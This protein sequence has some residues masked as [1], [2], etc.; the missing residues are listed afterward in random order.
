M[1]LI[2][3]V[4]IIGLLVSIIACS[5]ANMSFENIISND[6]DVVEIN[7]RNFNGY[8]YTMTNKEK[9]KE[10]LTIFQETSFIKT[11]KVDV[12][13]GVSLHLVDAEGNEITSI[14]PVDTN[15]FRMGETYYQSTSDIDGKV[16]AYIAEHFKH[17]NLVIEEGMVVNL[18]VEEIEKVTIKDFKKNVSKVIDNKDSIISIVNVF[19]STRK[20]EGIVN[21]AK[22]DY[23]LNFGIASYFVW[24]DGENITVQ[25]TKNTHTIFSLSSET[26]KE[27]ND[28]FIELFN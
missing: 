2:K 10:F 26:V 11:E 5:S 9:I 28:I 6:M 23:V 24:I 3:F 25:D 27:V 21:M 16:N 19:N 18:N 8:F 14:F 15:V 20:V 7:A 12:F 1:K 17:E 4:T 13:G 22:P